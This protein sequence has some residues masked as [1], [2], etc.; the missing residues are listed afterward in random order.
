MNNRRSPHWGRFR[1]SRPHFRPFR[2]RIAE[3]G[4]DSNVCIEA[5]K[6]PGAIRQ[7]SISSP[8]K[9][10][11]HAALFAQDALRSQPLHVFVLVAGRGCN[12]DPPFQQPVPLCSRDES[13]T[14][15]WFVTPEKNHTGV[16]NP[17]STPQLLHQRGEWQ[18]VDHIILREPTLACHSGAQTQ[19]AGV[20]EPV[21]VRVQYTLHP[22]APGVRPLAPVQVKSLG[23]AVQLE[24]GAGFGTGINDCLLVHRICLPPQQESPGEM[25]NHM[26]MRILNSAQN[27]LGVVRLVIRRHMQTGHH[28]IQLRQ[29]SIIKIQPVLQDINF[30]AGKESEVRPFVL[31]ALVDL[32]DF[33]DLF[34]KAWRASC[35]WSVKGRISMS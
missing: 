13:G 35:Q 9:P 34:S 5:N 12:P 7:H 27:A 6:L 18:G 25:A 30:G 15:L 32:S 16:P 21:G 2:G 22:L 1:N 24:P 23:I 17:V 31:Q 28:H 4:L 29:Q 8:I 14:V 33:L 10:T 11:G 19:K 26:H 3:V 20:L